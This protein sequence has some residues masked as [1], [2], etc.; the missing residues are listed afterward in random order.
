MM[1]NVKPIGARNINRI[2]MVAP[3]GLGTTVL[4]Q[5]ASS[6]AGASMTLTAVYRAV[7]FGYKAAAF[8]PRAEG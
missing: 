8:L 7:P 6:R 3:K 5:G 1:I 2:S 4:R